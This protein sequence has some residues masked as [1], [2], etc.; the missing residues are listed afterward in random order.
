MSDIT[1]D[2]NAEDVKYDILNL[3]K[4]INIQSIHEIYK[5][6]DYHIKHMKGVKE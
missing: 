4:A 3:I 6:V 2:D 1:Y 5:D